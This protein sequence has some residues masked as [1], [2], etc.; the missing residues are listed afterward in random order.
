VHRELVIARLRNERDHP[1]KF[2]LSPAWYGEEEEKDF[3]AEPGSR[4]RFVEKERA[5]RLGKPQSILGHG[6]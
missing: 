5:K 4:R 6:A 2:N 3:R 1:L